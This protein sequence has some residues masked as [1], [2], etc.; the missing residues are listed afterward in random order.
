[1]CFHTSQTKKVKEL[2]NT[3]KIDISD[4]ALVDYFDK[5][6]YHM[7]G[8]SHPN[9]LVIPQ[10]K[11]DVLAPGVWGIVPNNKS[12]DDIKSYYKE[13]VKYGAGLNAQSEKLFNHFIYRDSI[14]EKRCVI[15]V[16]GFFEPHE[17]EK[18]KYPFHIKDSKDGVLSLAGIYT[19]IDTFITFTILTKKASLLFQK[20]H[21]LR[22]RQPVL[23]SQEDAH[24]WLSVDLNQ[25]DITEIVNANYKDETLSAYTVSKD[26][27]NPK[28]DSDINSILDEVQYEGVSI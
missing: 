1:M 2:K 11:S 4:P 21:N 14:M 8:F 26:L 24:N 20:I 5:P 13:A 3:Y 19:V 25:N 23:L 16:T 22:K 28:I 9:M 6:R 18:K 17:Y 7:N 15:P 12:K 27:F 10:E